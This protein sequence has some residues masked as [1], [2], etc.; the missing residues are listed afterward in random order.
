MQADTFYFESII[1]DDIGVR[2]LVDL[3]CISLLIIHEIKG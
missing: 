3:D 2:S 1:Q